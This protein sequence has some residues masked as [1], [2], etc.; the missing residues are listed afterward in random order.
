[1]LLENW[2]NHEKEK[3]KKLRKTYLVLYPILSLKNIKL[4]NLILVSFNWVSNKGYYFIAQVTLVKSCDLIRWDALVVVVN[5]FPV[6][7]R[8]GLSVSVNC[9]LRK[10]VWNSEFRNSSFR[11]K[12]N[13]VS[14]GVS[15]KRASSGS[16]RTGFSHV[17][18]RWNPALLLGLALPRRQ[19]VL[20]M[21]TRPLSYLVTLTGSSII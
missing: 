5:D 14:P 8:P 18:A 4:L 20:H 16:R 2:Y 12:I 21:N 10:F 15:T 6:I 19:P 3:Q 11:G 1:M 13:V 9:F 7:D 17:N